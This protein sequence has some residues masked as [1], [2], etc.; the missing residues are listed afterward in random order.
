[1]SHFCADC[2]YEYDEAT[3]QAIPTGLVRCPNCGSARVSANAL[4]GVA[5]GVGTAY[6]ASILITIHLWLTWLR[7]AI[8]QAKK[9][10]RAREQIMSRGGQGAIGSWMEQEFEAS[11]VAVAA[12]AHALDA[13]YGSLVIPQSVRDHWKQKGT[14]RHGKLREA[15]KQVFDTG[16]VNQKWVGEFDWLFSYETPHCM[17]RKPRRSRCC[18]PWVPTPRRSRLT[19]RSSRLNAPWSVPCRSSAGASITLARTSLRPCSGRTPHARL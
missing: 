19:T 7:I 3:A 5:E 15:L 12:S 14:K 6:D 13:L 16:P 11:V 18:I 4:A 10:H 8:E 2:E 17:P 9:A 1:M